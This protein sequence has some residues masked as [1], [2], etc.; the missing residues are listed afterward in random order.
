MRRTIL[1]LIIGLAAGYRWGY[2]EGAAGKES[3]VTRTLND[4]GTSKIKAAQDAREKRVE[5]ASK[6]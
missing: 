3:I 2:D 5:D 4:F 6:P 1:A